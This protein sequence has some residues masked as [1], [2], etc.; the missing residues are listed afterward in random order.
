MLWCN[1]RASMFEMSIFLILQHA[2]EQRFFLSEPHCKL[3]S[4][5][6]Q[7]SPCTKIICS[8]CKNADAFTLVPESHSETLSWAKE[9]AL[10][11]TISHDINEM[12]CGP[13]FKKSC[14]WGF[15]SAEAHIFSLPF[16][17]F[18]RQRSQNLHYSWRGKAQR[19]ASQN[20]G[21]GESWLLR[22]FILLSA[23][24]P[25]CV[26]LYIWILFYFIY[27][28]VLVWFFWQTEN[29]HQYSFI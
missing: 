10:W 19:S 16:T 26:Y 7:Y 15:D 2:L 27:F 18:P 21:R 1:H 11:S 23:T 6:F 5:V 4:S 12:V 20:Q 28:F 9:S 14:C 8:T 25:F 13:S 29:L 22:P 17:F 24:F 3:F